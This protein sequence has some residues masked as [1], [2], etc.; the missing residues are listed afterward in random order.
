MNTFLTIF[1]PSFMFPIWK[2]KRVNLSLQKCYFKNALWGLLG[3]SFLDFPATG[4][5]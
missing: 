5:N 4:L 2:L 1:E 3:D